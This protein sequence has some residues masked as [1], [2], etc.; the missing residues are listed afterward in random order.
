MAEGNSDSQL[1]VAQVVFFLIGAALPLSEGWSEQL[2]K[3]QE[4]CFKDNLLIASDPR[5]AAVAAADYATYTADSSAMQQETG[6]LN[7][8]LQNEKTQVTTLG[9][10]LDQVYNLEEP[11]VQLQQWLTHGI[12]SFA[13]MH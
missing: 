2:T 10:A 4:V 11:M 13:M 6:N 1:S 5:Y 3:D 9:N 7:N 12:S 8:V